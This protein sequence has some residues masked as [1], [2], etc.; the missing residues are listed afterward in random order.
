MALLGER[1]RQTGDLFVDWIAA[2]GWKL[3]RF[4]E[5]VATRERAIRLFRLRPT[6]KPEV[7]TH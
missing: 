3:D 1:G 7:L 2:R 5:K 4:E 6:I